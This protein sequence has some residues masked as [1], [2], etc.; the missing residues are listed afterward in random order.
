M[1]KRGK[2]FF[3]KIRAS[4]TKN[5]EGQSY[6]SGREL[7]RT[8]ARTLGFVFFLFGTFL[9]ITAF[10]RVPITG[11]TI[12]ESKATTASIL[13]IALEVIGITLIVLNKKC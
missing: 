3:K 10:L 5:Q 12:A 2:K 4:F 11:F 6:I 13:G 9:I 7:S 8:F 1:Q